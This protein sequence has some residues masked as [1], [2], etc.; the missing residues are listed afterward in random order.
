MKFVYVLKSEKTSIY[1]VG[2][3]V[4]VDNRLKE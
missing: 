2:I 4:N 3:T 1:Y